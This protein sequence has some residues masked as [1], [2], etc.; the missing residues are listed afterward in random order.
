[1]YFD[2]IDIDDMDPEEYLDHCREMR[3][4][5]EGQRS[6][7]DF[8]KGSTRGNSMNL[9]DDWYLICIGHSKFI[10]DRHRHAD[11]QKSL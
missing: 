2:N 9:E 4:Y 11:H 3:I 5:I 6:I 10:I 8:M 1:M 7:I